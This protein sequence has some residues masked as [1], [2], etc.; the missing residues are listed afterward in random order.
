MFTFTYL[1]KYS[2]GTCLCVC[3]PVYLYVSR[4][5]SNDTAHFVRGEWCMRL[6]VLNG[7]FCYHCL[8]IMFI[9]VIKW[10]FLHCLY[11]YVSFIQ[12]NFNLL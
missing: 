1:L 9:S 12:Q 4:P 11:T 5:C 8:Q 3:A 7:K 10:E 2:F 6:L